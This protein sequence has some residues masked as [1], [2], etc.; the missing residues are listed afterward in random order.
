M[1]KFSLKQNTSNGINWAK[2]KQPNGEKEAYI[3]SASSNARNTTRFP[4]YKLKLKIDSSDDDD[5]E[6]ESK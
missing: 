6:M 5:N 4:A 3:E 1:H 2:A